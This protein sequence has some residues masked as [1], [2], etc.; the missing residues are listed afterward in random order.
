MTT[1]CF[2]VLG[3]PMSKGSMTGELVTYG[4]GSPLIKN[5]KPLV[6]VRPNK[7]RALETNAQG[8][9][10]VALA[11]RQQAGFG[12]LRDC[13][14]HV[15]ARFYMPSPA[16][17]YG[18]GR[19]AGLL[20]DSAAARPAKKPDADK[21]ARQLLDAI[22]GVIYADDGQV[23]SLLCEKHYAEGDQVPCTEVEVSVL[24]QQTVG[25]VVPDEQMALAA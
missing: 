9:A 7:G 21:L 20:K 25:V 23:V 4:D 3:E 14:I 15:T 22:T 19:N 10:R 18:S 12:L 1:L 11:A 6:R 13:A 16:Y 8:I 24:L 2:T 5:G 17:R